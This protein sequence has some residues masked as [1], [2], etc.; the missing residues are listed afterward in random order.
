MALDT[1]KEVAIELGIGG[2]AS[3]AFTVPHVVEKHLNNEM[4]D[5]TLHTLGVVSTTLIAGVALHLVKKIID[6]R[7]KEKA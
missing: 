7:G 4:I 5:W 2:T 6:K 1:F 3:I